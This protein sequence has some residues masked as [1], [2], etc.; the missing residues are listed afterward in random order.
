NA[1]EKQ[2]PDLIL[3]DVEM[4]GMDGYEVLA[5]LKANKAT[6]HIP[7]IFLTAL[8]S[9]DTE[10]K[11]LSK[12]A[13]DYITKPFSPPLLLKRIELH[14]QLVDYR[15]NLEQL[16][17][18]KTDEVVAL[19]NAV[20]RTTAELV[21]HRDSTTGDHIDRTQSYIKI[22]L[23]A[24]KKYDIYKEDLASLDE[25]LVLQSSQLHDVGKISIKDSILLKTGTLTAEEF[26][27]MKSHTT[28][29]ESIILNI[30]ESTAGVSDFLDYAMVFAVSH[31]E[32]WDG[33]GYPKG[34]AGED[35]PLLGRIMA[36]ADVYDALVTDRPY[37]KAYPHDVATSTIRDGSG[38]HFDPALVELFLK[39]STE[40]EKISASICASG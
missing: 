24:S 18:Q 29:G 31:H 14:L 33:S 21:E 40:F 35:I 38:S 10:L 17:E 12:G 7:V 26:E 22:L 5:R 23:D 8:S 15:S 36:I 28:F 3:L 32:K 25:N 11:G 37:K 16:V 2:V 13:V 39:V 20:L 34:L 30:K 1:L 27:E 9:D 6:E 4:P 19:K